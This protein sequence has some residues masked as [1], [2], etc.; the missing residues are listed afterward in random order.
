MLHTSKFTYLGNLKS[1]KCY[2]HVWLAET[3]HCVPGVNYDDVGE[4]NGRAHMRNDG[5]LQI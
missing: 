1:E 5:S 4:N 3:S 2:P